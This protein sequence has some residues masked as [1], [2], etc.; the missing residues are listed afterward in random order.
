LKQRL[1]ISLD[2][3]DS[4]RQEITV[5]QHALE[6][7]N[8]PIRFEP[9]EK[10]HLTLNFIGAVEKDRVGSLQNL[11]RRVADTY[12]PLTLTP[13]FLETLYQKH[14]SSLIY[15]GLTGDT[16][17]LDNLHDDLKENLAEQ[18]IP[19][20]ERYMPHITI[21]RFKK[22]DPVLTK[23]FMDKVNAYEFTAL[24][25]FIADRISLYESLLSRDGSHY[26]RI[27]LHLLK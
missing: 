7:L 13:A 6:K 25:P 11:I 19:Q 17:G 20:P 8:L 16:D 5:L 9:P 14:D 24:T 2:P 27:G 15:L 23:S 21:G 12:A 3:P 26:R 10:L 18:Q 1:F 22:A 4:T